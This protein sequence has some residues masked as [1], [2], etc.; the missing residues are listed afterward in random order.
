VSTPLSAGGVGMYIEKLKYTV[1]EK[2]SNEVFRALWIEIYLPKN[3]NIICGVVY[4]Q[5]Y[6]RDEIIEILA[7]LESKSFLWVIPT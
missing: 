1:L 6:S 5:H 2:C 7:L 4:R 3:R